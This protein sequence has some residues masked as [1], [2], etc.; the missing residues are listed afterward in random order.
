VTPRRSDHTGA[1]Y[2]TRSRGGLEE[3]ERKRDFARTPEPRGDGQRKKARRPLQFVVQQHAARRLHYDFRLELDGVLKSW[4]IPKGPSLVAGERRMAVQ[5]EDHPLEYATFEGV[6]PPGEYG[7][8]AVVV[9]DRGTWR[10]IGDARR[11]LASGKLDFELAGEKLRG[12]WHLV[13]MRSRPRERKASWL[14]IKGR[15]DAARGSEEDAITE[16][17]PQSVLTGRGL[18]EVARDADR[19]W[20]SRTGERS[21]PAIPTPGN[22][23]TIPGARR[24]PL[25]RRVAPELATLVEAPPEGDEWLHEI[26]LDGY[27]VL[28]R[29]EKGRASMHTRAGHDWTEHFP[30]IARALAELPVK[31]ALID[32]E[33]VVFGADGR[34]RFQALQGALGQDR[35][36][37]VLVGFD[38]LHLDGWDLRGAALGDRKRAL[39]QR[40]LFGARGVLRYGDHVRGGGPAFFAAAC[41]KGVEGIVS[42]L[43]SAPYRAG[44]TRDWRKVRCS[45]RQEFAIVGFT[46]P[47]G[48]RV[49]FGAL[50]LGARDEAGALRYCGKVGT[51]F[52]HALLVRL[53]RE[54][55]ALEVD[56][57]PVS[58]PPRERGIHWV[59]PMRV[60]EVSFTEWT[61][62]GKVRHPSF[63]G[64]RE[65]KPAAEVRIEVPERSTK[66]RASR[67]SGRTS[68]PAIRSEVAGVRLSNPD[69]VYFPELGVTKSEL[70][71]HYETMAERAL[72]GLVNRPLTMLRCPEGRTGECFYQKHANE[73]I[74]DRVARVIVRKGG[75]PYAMVTDLAS[76]VSLVQIGVLELHVWG[77]RADRL[78][79]PDQ[80]VIDLDPDPA[81]P[82]RRL[83]DTAKLLGATFADLGLV[84]FVRTTG[85]KGLHVVVPLVRRSTWSEV[86]EFAH[87]IATALEREAPSYYTANMSKRRRAGR[88]YVDWLRNDF[89]STAIA[90][91]SIRAREGAPVAMPLSWEELDERRMPRFDVRSA[92]A[93]LALA[94]PWADFERSRRPLRRTKEP[95]G[96]TSGRPRRAAQRTRRSDARS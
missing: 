5:T 74:P 83:A 85:G 32:G 47:A 28:C 10:P 64:L 48:S 54:L 27:R 18:A 13:R 19:V 88:I 65:D 16:Q 34:T 81:V 20:S 42:K 79:R 53:R 40:V 33:A 55:A 89:E 91:Y 76:L 23:S 52:D 95:T 59:E 7:G 2:A 45:Q 68:P 50:L 22:P 44:R 56:T 58:D 8:G 87:G 17:K 69:R 77:A 6:I 71:Q 62:D 66:R 82:W 43:A 11:G 60:A 31:S 14:L 90:S 9:W 21:A 93:R 92:P 57:P 29:V 96:G 84:P 61:H 78:D 94:D 70:A 39:Q 80:L 63:L 72:P 12:R 15:D 38:L 3:Y 73:S 75:K 36:D 49:G 30:G 4:A 1:T 26:K 51:G 35:P 46:E 86:K 67:R 41:E 24:A 25:P 37:L